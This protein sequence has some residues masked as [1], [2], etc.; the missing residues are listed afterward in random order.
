[1]NAGLVPGIL[2]DGYQRY[3]GKRIYEICFRKKN[4]DDANF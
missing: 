3:L 2:I 1:M 4:K